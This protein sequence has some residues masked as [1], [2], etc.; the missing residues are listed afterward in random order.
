MPHKISQREA[1]QLLKRVAELERRVEQ[2]NI[3]ACSKVD[4]EILRA[5]ARHINRVC[6]AVKP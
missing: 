1:R 4:M 6:D 3:G 5:F 2:N